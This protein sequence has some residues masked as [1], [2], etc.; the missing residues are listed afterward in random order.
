[1]ARLLASLWRICLLRAGPQD[2]PY[3][4]RLSHGLVLLGLGID[5]LFVRYAGEGESSLART[6]FSLVL[7]LVLP[8]LLLAW[9]ERSPRYAQTLAAFAGTGVLFRLFF[10]PIALQALRMPPLLEGQA[11]TPGQSLVTLA[12]FFA[13][14]WRL[15]IEGHIWRHALDWPRYAGLALAAALF[16]AELA[17]AR[18]WFPLEGAP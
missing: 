13:V 10:I 9:R 16:V 17:L 8:W 18:W 12:A 7:L 3:S 1:M 6:L 15:A 4:P 11:P 2:L 5:L 14:G